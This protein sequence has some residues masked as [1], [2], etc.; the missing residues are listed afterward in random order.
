MNDKAQHQVSL[1]EC[2]EIA[3]RT[4][5]A[6]IGLR[7]KILRLESALTKIAEG[8]G[9]IPDKSTIYMNGRV[10]EV[11]KVFNMYDMREIAASALNNVTNEKVY[12]NDLKITY[13]ELLEQNLK[14]ELALQHIAKGNGTYGDATGCNPQGF[15]EVAVKALQT[16]GRE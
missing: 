13:K 14:F 11:P 3:E 16:S 12:M 5:I 15:C 6:N 2:A 7:E 8:R 1:Q 10:P 4:V 9:M